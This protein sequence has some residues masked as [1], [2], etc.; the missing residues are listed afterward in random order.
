M[1][2]LLMGVAASGKST[3]GR[4][5]AERLGWKFIDGDDLHPETNVA[6]MRDGHP[7]D[8]ADREPWLNKI[9]QT[10]DDLLAENDGAVVACSALKEAYRQRLLKPGVALVY[11]RVSPQDADRRAS[12]RGHAYMPPSLVASQFD[13]LEE[14]EK[15]LITVDASRPVAQIVNDIAALVET[16]ELR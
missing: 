13:T 6:K 2:I 14:P 8:D 10:M 3:V 7:L 1:I 15:T 16:H 5:L 12:S 9:S 4:A 11:L